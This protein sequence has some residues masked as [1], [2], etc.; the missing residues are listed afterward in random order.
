MPHRLH[1]TLR[2]HTAKST[3]SESWTMRMPQA[4]PDIENSH[5]QVDSAREL[6]DENASG[7]TRHWELAL[8]S[9]QRQRAGQWECL[10]LHQ[11]LRT[12]TAKSTAP[13]SWTMRMHHRLY[14]TLRSHTTRSTSKEDETM[15]I[16]HRL[17]RHWELTPLWTAKESWTMRM[18]YSPDVV[19]AWIPSSG[20][21]RNRLDRRN[22]TGLNSIQ[23]AR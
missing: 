19:N 1:Q 22:F 8:P 2:T 7:F 21:S 5:C 23:V 9:R 12:H 17:R 4:S 14:Q 16:H 6:D 15:R 18:H 3:A 13:E 10:R 11:T 20:L